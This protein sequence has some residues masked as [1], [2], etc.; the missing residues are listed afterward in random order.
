MANIQQFNDWFKTAQDEWAEYREQAR[1][2]YKFYFG[3]Q[4]EAD[5]ERKM[6][7][8][9]K[10]SLVFNKIKPII[11][12]LSGYQRQNRRDIRVAPRRGGAQ[13]VASIYTELIKYV[14][15]ISYCDWYSAYMFVDGIIGGKGWL[16]VDVDYSRD[17]LSGDLN[18]MREDPFLILEDPFSQKYDLSDARYI[19]RSRWIDKKMTEKMFPKVK[20]LQIDLE[21]E[22]LGNVEIQTDGFSDIEKVYN[23]EIAKSRYL[24]KECWYR[25]YNS[26]KF[27]V[28]ASGE[29]IDIGSEDEEL[30]KNILVSRP[31]LRTIER[32]M[33]RLKMAII[34]GNQII[35]EEDDPYNGA[36]R[37]PIVR[38]ANELIYAEKPMVRGEV[39]DIIS[40]QEEHNKRKS[41]AL[42]HLNSSAS[43][44]FIVEKGAMSADELRKLESIGS[45]PGITIAVE[46][47]KLGAIQRINPAPLSDGH[48]NLAGIADADMK[49]ISGVN[50]DLLGMDK[51]QSQSGVAMEMR[52]RQGLIN[53]EPVFD[54]NDFTN[55]VLGDTLL[56]IIR[57]TEVYTTEEIVSIVGNKVV[58]LDG[59]SV[60]ADVIRA[61]MKTRK[62][63]YSVAMSDQQNNPTMRMAQFQDMISAVKEAGIPV[64][65]EMIVDSSDWDFKD[66]W[67]EWFKQQQAQQTQGM[68]QDIP[69]DAPIPPEGMM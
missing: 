23:F 31:D 62:G 16:S 36:N 59:K 68:P 26:Q 39:E 60:S 50:A 57:K 67:S 48:I 15:D 30:I 49:A 3:E 8:E 11:R 34:L 22:G 13:T 10:P 37:F 53:Q 44:G 45:R 56:D 7:L 43:S 25:D 51:T 32:V 38:F 52:R 61:F 9:G 64:P 58:T 69:Q 19:F 40:P 6:R 46:D 54:N 12:T 21:K 1:K 63:M 14:M 47:G 2:S 65:P 20:D 24:I 33:P 66:K 17:P 42:H 28:S 29:L 55:R 35:H 41:Q 4:W 27:L 18:V 5:L